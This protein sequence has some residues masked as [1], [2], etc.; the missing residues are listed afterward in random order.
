MDK[1]SGPCS[2]KNVTEDNLF[3]DSFKKP[4]HFHMTERSFDENKMMP[5][6][7]CSEMYYLTYP[8]YF[9]TAYGANFGK[10]LNNKL[11]I[12]C[13]DKNKRVNFILHKTPSPTYEKLKNIVKKALG[14]SMIYQVAMQYC[15]VKLK[16]EKEKGLK[17][18]CPKTEM[19]NKNDFNINFGDEEGKSLCPAGFRSMFPYHAIMHL[20]RKIGI[21]NRSFPLVTCP[22]HLKQLMFSV[23]KKP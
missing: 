23:Q 4:C 10:E 18:E 19:F 3:L 17:S 20:R 22:D 6:H 1:N 15:G 8:Y 2:L 21:K 9:A 14:S 12:K 7:I 5:K 16:V 11:T 13:P